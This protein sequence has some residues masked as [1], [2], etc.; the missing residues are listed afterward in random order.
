MSS[1]VLSIALTCAS[2]SFAL[3]TSTQPDAASSLDPDS[4]PAARCIGYTRAGDSAYR[5]VTAGARWLAAETA[6][7]ADE[8]GATHLA[9]VDAMTELAAI[10]E[11]TTATV[12]VGLSDRRSEGSWQ[13]VS[14]TAQPLGTPLWKMGEPSAGGKDNCGLLDMAGHSDAIN[15]DDARPYLCE[16]DGVAAVATSY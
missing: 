10:H 14:G 4:A 11:V 6:C 15:C 3:P 2:C 1:R 5:V 12:W 7:E 9:I 13:W 16:C 8:P